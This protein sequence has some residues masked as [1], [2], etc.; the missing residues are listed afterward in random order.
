MKKILKIVLTIIVIFLICLVVKLNILDFSVFKIDEQR[1]LD[2]AG[3]YFNQLD[4]DEKEIYIKI[5]DAVKN[6][7]ETVFLGTIDSEGLSDKV[8]KVLTAYFYDNPHIYYISNRY[9]VA[10]RDVK[11]FEFSTLD[12]N[13]IINSKEEI[14]AKNKQ[15]D[16]AISEI[17]NSNITE[18]MTE[19]EKELAI[20]DALVEQVD[21]YNYENIEDIPSIKHTAYGALIQN[22]AV[23]DGYSKA[24]KLLLQKVGIDNIIVYGSTEEVAHAWNAVS[25]G[26]EYYHV[27]VTSDKLD[28]SKKY[29]IHTYFN[30]TD[31][32]ISKTHSINNDFNVP[33]CNS[34]KYNYY[35]KQGYTIYE[36]DNLYNKLD[37]IIAKQSKSPI[38]EI[39]LD[40]KYTAKRLID[41]LY[42]L[43]FN[44][45]RSDRKNRVEYTQVQDKYIFV[46]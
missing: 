5:D 32:Q 25:I 2:Y 24:F 11:F 15:L 8:G 43:D 44:N 46:K 23:C 42:D 9:V 33:N 40:K 36:Q 39:M 30:L 34:E 28:I 22:E 3:Y 37:Q 18:N 17:I 14:E 7:R 26:N 21:Y 6:I 38:L 41:D 16:S 45:W 35:N 10:T 31:E 20:H 29:V 1:F 4:W 12:L 19:Y 13:Y 27:D